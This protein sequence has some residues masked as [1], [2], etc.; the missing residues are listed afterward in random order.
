MRVTVL[1]ICGGSG[2]GKSTVAS[3]LANYGACVLDA[4]R[5]YHELVDAPSACVR[6]LA[7]EF[8]EGI[9]A[10]DGSLD[11]RAL[12]R[13]VFFG[14]GAPQRLER[15]NAISHAYVKDAIH[16][17]MADL[18]AE[19]VGC[20][21]IDAPLLFESHLDADCD[22]VIAVI[23]DDAVRVERMVRRDAI[24]EEEAWRRIRAQLSNDEL[25]R[26]CRFTVRNDGD[27]HALA[28][29]LQALWEQLKQAYFMN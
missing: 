17:R 7:E 19:G 4:D 11:R 1:G 26:R 2:S 27:T 15:L 29:A 14:D 12:S 16:S 8:G 20:V 28:D 25:C 23:A 9:V 18:A 21:V 13:I 6:A 3:M 24:T 5:V 10:A 22:A